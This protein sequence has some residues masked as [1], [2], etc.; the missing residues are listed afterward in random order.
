MYI[1]LSFNRWNKSPHCYYQDIAYCWNGGIFTLV[2]MMQYSTRI[3]IRWR[4]L[5]GTY[6]CGPG[7]TPTPGHILGFS[8]P[9]GWSKRR[10]SW[11]WVSVAPQP[12]GGVWLTDLATHECASLTPNRQ[13]VPLTESPSY[14]KYICLYFL[15]YLSDH[16]NILHIPRQLCCL[17]MCQILL[18]S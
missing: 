12:A 7:R 1:S 13:I 4:I 17:G 2:Y 8:W 3:C 14:L 16:N 5:R 9:A 18:W 15:S 11:W 10:R 6:Q